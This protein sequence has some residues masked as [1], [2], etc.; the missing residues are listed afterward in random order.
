MPEFRTVHHSLPHGDSTNHP[1]RIVVHAMGQFLNHGGEKILAPEFLD[2]LGFSAH[3]LI[4]T[5]GTRLRC[6]K[7]TDGA[8]HAKGHNTNTLGVEVLCPDAPNL[9]TLKERTQGAWI[10]GNQMH[11]LV[12]LVRGWMDEWDI[13]RE[14]VV[15]HSDLDPERKWFDPGEG[16]PW[17]V[18]RAELGRVA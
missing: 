4:D 1:E 9:A 6:R 16:F 18:F 15:R 17:E 12:Q 10:T 14:Q 8:Y 5:D 13:S 2:R 7:D 3:C 11:S